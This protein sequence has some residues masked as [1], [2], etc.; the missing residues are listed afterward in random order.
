MDSE[1]KKE[2]LSAIGRTA[3]GVEKLAD[4]VAEMRRVVTDAR[5]RVNIPT[6]TIRTWLGLAQRIEDASGRELSELKSDLKAALK[7]VNADIGMKNS[8]LA[9]CDTGSPGAQETVAGMRRSIADGERLLTKYEKEF[10]VVVK[11]IGE[12]GED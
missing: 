9:Q 7:I 11:P 3:N 5:N 8:I 2:E 1:K 4:I 10:Q 12:R 6:L